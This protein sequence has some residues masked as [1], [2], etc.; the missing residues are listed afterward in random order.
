MAAARAARSGTSTGA[1]HAERDE[2]YVRTPD[3]AHIRV[4]SFR[5]R[6]QPAARR[7]LFVPGFLSF[8]ESWNLVLA[9]M[10]HSFDVLYLESREKRS[11]QVHAHSRFGIAE[12]VADLGAAIRHFDLRPGRFDIVA[13]CSGAAT[14]LQAH[15]SLGIRPAKMVWIQPALRPLLPWM[16]LPLSRVLRGPL[17]PLLQ[18]IAVAWYRRFLNPPTR[19]A[20]QHS[21]FMDVVARADPYKTT[22]AARDIYH[23]N[24]DPELARCVASPVLILAASHDVSHRFD[25]MVRLARTLPDARFDDLGMFWRTRAPAAGRAIVR[26]LA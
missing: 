21:R 14:V 25:D 19:D 7:V 1:D 12:L 17:Y 5:S 26:F 20:F 4:L 11:S 10:R 8:V 15:V 24:L 16:V 9:E 13:S 23:L 18:R 22:R 3:G 6:V 2:T